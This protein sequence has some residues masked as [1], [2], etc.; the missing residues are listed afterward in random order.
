MNQEYISTV[1]NV[2]YVTND[3]V[4]LLLE[5]EDPK[6][7]TFQA[8]QFLMLQIPD[9]RGGLISRLYSIASSPTNNREVVFYIKIVPHG[10]ATSEIKFLEV[11]KEILLRGPNGIFSLHDDSKKHLYMISNGVGVTPFMSMMAYL[12]ET[13]DPRNVTALWGLRRDDDIF[14]RDFFENLPYPV[15][16]CLSQP[17]EDW[18]GKNGRVTTVLEN[19][20]IDVEDS[21]FYLCGSKVMIQDV[22]EILASKGITEEAIYNEKFY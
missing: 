8:G 2:H 11:G 12:H 21:A 9:H 15:H 6:T 22:K 16:I 18:T 3:V 17:K 7:I 14:C 10:K 5:L 13:N 1:K 4:E 19:M 20:D